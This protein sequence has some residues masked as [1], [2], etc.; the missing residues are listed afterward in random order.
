MDA[1]VPNHIAAPRELL[2]ALIARMRRGGF[3]LLLV[4]PPLA[5]L[6]RRVL[7]L[8]ARRG[9]RGRRRERLLGLVLV[10]AP[11]VHVV[12][13]G[14]GVVRRVLESVLDGLGVYNIILGHDT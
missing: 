14:Q 8:A 7:R 10:S 6:P 5:L 9:C 12:E 11:A 13:D 1:H 2:R 3:L 4:C